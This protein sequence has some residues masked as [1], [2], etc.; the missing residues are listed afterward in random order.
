MYRKTRNSLLTERVYTLKRILLKCYFT[1]LKQSH[2]PFEYR[3]PNTSVWITWAIDSSAFSVPEPTSLPVASSKKFKVLCS[4]RKPSKPEI[5]D[6]L[7]FCFVKPTATPV[8][9]DSAYFLNSLWYF[10]ISLWKW[11]SIQMYLYY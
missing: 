7:I 11:A 10:L 2:S 1:Y 8:V 3:I 6:K 4:I 9:Y 5:A